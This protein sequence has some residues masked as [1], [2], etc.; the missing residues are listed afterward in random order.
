MTVEAS[1]SSKISNPESVARLV[2]KMCEGNMQVLL[3]HRDSGQVTIRGAFYKLGKFK[4]SSAILLHKISDAGLSKLDTGM[5][6]KIEV[7]G[8][9]SQLTFHTLVVEKTSTGIVCAMPRS[10]LSTERRTNTRFRA[11]PDLSAFMSFSFWKA[12]PHD[13]AA[14]PFFASYGGIA[15]WIAVADISVG[16][17]CLLSRFPAFQNATEGLSESFDCALH[18]PM[19]TPLQIS[20]VIRWRRKIKNRV[21]TANASERFQLEYR[22]GLEFN[23][24]NEEEQTKIRQYIRQLTVSEAI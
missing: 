19:A 4:Q 8:M 15:H 13:P 23:D 24:L 20:G 5:P 7:L 17:V 12:H 14:Q 22:I 10:L 21:E 16:G 3:R 9:A 1:G 6:I 11:T 18:L 2:A